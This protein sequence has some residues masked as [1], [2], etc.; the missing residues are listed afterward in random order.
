MASNDT[1]QH[2]DSN[3]E[4]LNI[5]NKVKEMDAQLSLIIKEV[6]KL[7]S[8]GKELKQHSI[9]F[10]ES[11]KKENLKAFTDILENAKRLDIYLKDNF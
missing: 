7:D 10:K 6:Q 5:D 3:M 1:Y 8:L 9:Q 4:L 11:W 2:I